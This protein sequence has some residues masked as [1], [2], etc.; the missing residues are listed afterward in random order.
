MRRHR[1]WLGSCLA[2]LPLVAHAADTRP[3]ATGGAF[4]LVVALCYFTRKRPI[5]GWLM[6]FCW[7]LYGGILLTLV[8]TVGH[9]KSYTP[10]PWDDRA[11]YTLFLLS[12]APQIVAMCVQAVMATI[13]LWRRTP[14]NLQRLRRV[15]AV[16]VALLVGAVLIDYTNFDGEAVYLDAL[17]LVSTAIWL[18]YFYRSVRVSWVFEHADWPWSYE[19][20]IGKVGV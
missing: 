3:A 15:M 6:V 7:S 16:T 14:E 10:E 9:W 18:A 20:M 4:W 13:L 17:P 2:L 8:F 12:S 11:K 5:G 1:W 19:R